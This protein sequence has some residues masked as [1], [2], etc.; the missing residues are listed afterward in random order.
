MYLCNYLMEI[1]VGLC[2]WVNLLDMDVFRATLMICD[3]V[4]ESLIDGVVVGVACCLICAVRWVHRMGS[5]LLIQG[6][7][8][9]WC[10]L[11]CYLIRLWR[12]CR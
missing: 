3:G 12:F 7:F 9:S 10:S 4:V 8:V 11:V 5:R 1:L 2:V 6:V